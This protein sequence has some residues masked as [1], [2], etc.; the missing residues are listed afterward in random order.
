MSEMYQYNIK[1]E[2][3]DS[4]IEKIKDSPED[5]L[6]YKK[7]K[8]MK[9]IFNAFPLISSCTIKKGKVDLYIWAQMRLEN[10]IYLYF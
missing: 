3:L 10:K 6:L 8:D 5:I 1:R 7:L 4:V 2:N 9:A